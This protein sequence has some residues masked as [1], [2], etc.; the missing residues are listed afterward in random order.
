MLRKNIADVALPFEYGLV[1]PGVVVGRPEIQ[2]LFR[3]Q[4]AEDFPVRPVFQ[5]ACRITSD[6]PYLRNRETV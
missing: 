1:D 6:I 5:V 4:F 3:P 2:R